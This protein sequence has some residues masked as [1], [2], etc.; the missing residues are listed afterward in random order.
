[1]TTLFLH[2][3]INNCYASIFRIFK[4]ELNGVPLVVLSNNDGSIIARSQDY[5]EYK[6]GEKTITKAIK[7]YYI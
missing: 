1:M 2:A 6:S 3:D 7:I 4:P 5:V